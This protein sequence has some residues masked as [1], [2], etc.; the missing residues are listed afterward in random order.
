MSSKHSKK[1]CVSNTSIN[2]FIK[3][4]LGIQIEPDLKAEDSQPDFILECF[5]QAS[6]KL[7][8]VHLT[9]IPKQV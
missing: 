1:Q 4:R 5:Y 9:E 8:L 6:I 3:N 7:G 2:K